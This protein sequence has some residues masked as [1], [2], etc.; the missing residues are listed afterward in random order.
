MNLAKLYILST[1]IGINYFLSFIMRDVS[2]SY[3]LT[4]YQTFSFKSSDFVLNSQTF[5]YDSFRGE[6]FVKSR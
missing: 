4:M 1:C 6:K 3:P 2:S 5:Q